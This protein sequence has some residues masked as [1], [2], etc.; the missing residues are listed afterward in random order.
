MQRKAT[1]C[2]LIELKTFTRKKGAQLWSKMSGKA[3]GIIRF[4][5][6][7]WSTTRERDGNAETDAAITE[8]NG[9]DLLIYKQS[10]PPVQRV[11]LIQEFDGSRTFL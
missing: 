4:W 11:I 2:W 6:L 5:S 9:T 8:T 3:Y 1:W 7:S 10:G